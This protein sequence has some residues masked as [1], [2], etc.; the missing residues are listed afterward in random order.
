MR[1][2]RRFG[3]VGDDGASEEGDRTECSSRMSSSER[4]AGM[5]V[6][7]ASESFTSHRSCRR[8]RRLEIVVARRGRHSGSVS[9]DK[10]YILHAAIGIAAVGG[11]LIG[12]SAG[13][14]GCGAA[15]G[16]CAADCAHLASETTTS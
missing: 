16:C 3:R 11:L 5:T 4:S 13:G 6:A 12:L 8:C 9:A 1:R 10:T 15:D 7:N 14:S 2:G